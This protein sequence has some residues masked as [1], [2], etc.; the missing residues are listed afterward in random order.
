MFKG[1]KIMKTFEY[2]SNN[3]ITYKLVKSYMKFG[4]AESQ[5]IYFFKKNK[6]NPKIHHP[7]PEIPN[8]WEIAE[9]PKNGYPLL[10]RGF[11]K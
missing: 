11:K 8:G 1:W 7:V 10:Q 5:P 6:I 4:N 2:Q 3:G 9:N